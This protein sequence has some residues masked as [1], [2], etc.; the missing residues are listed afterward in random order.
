MVDT[1]T[2]IK[3]QPIEVGVFNPSIS[4]A[5]L[6]QEPAPVPVVRRTTELARVHRDYPT[7]DVPL[8]SAVDDMLQ[9][10]PAASSFRSVKRPSDLAV[11]RARPLQVYVEPQINSGG[12]L[13]ILPLEVAA[14]A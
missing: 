10:E 1:A 6:Q 3:S 13:D 12:V 8:R 2:T 9:Q 14:D 4:R 7:H 5:D 11:A